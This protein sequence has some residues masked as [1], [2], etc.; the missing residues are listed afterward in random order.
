M[1]DSLDRVLVALDGS[2]HSLESVRYV[3]GI[4]DPNRFCLVLFHIIIRV[5]ESFMDF[6]QKG[7]GYNYKLISVTAWEEK[8]KE[9]IDGFMSKAETILSE[10]GFPA[11]A[12]TKRI[13][14]RKTGIARDIA[15]ESQR[16]YKALVLGR[17]G[18]SDLKDFMLGSVAQHL[19]GVV[20][21]PVWIVGGSRRRP[22]RILL[23][24]DGSEQ[25]MLCL[26]HL[27]AILKDSKDFQI[28]LFHAVRSFYGFRTFM[29]EVFSFETDK[30][31]IE[32]LNVELDQAASAMEPSFENARA[33]LTA[34]GVDA[35]HIGQKIARGVSNSAQAIIEEAE[36]GDYDTILVGR[37]GLSRVEEFAIGRVSNRVIN[38]AKDKTVWVVS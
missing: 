16:G 32:R 7:T 15:E 18:L 3:A 22:S 34:H 14:G 26:P 21:I 28:T 19:L 30:E 8:Q 35:E 4:L 36:N 9:A 37:R 29:R 27:A 25:S 6:E 33:I 10:A 11:Y 12:I 13:E 20:Q 23:C 5:P 31:A 38:M 17:R 1:S 2:E 24:L